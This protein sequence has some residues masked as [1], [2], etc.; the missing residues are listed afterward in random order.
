MVSV[1]TPVYNEANHLPF[2]LAHI[3]KAGLEELV[4][5]DGESVDQTLNHLKSWSE[6]THRGY[7]KLVASSRKGRAYQ[8]NE[9]AQLASGEILIFLHADSYLPE[10]GIALVR[11]AMKDP[12]LAGGSFRLEIDSVHWF[13]KLVSTMANLRSKYC[14]LPYGDQAFFVRKEVF[15]R[16]GGYRDI[17]LMEDVDFFRRLKK[18]GKTILL[19]EA[20]LTSARRWYKKGRYLNS[21]RN[22]IFLCLYFT[23]VSPK[24]LEKWYYP[25]SA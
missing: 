24:R 2:F 13:L 7:H 16:M 9:G 6:N 19:K 3:E 8:M 14:R 4:V 22:V 11:F 12:A 15:E 21:F 1:I 25:P 10:N 23:G 20:V 17:P 18:E 5:I